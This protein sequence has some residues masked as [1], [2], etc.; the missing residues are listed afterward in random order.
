MGADGCGGG[1]IGITEEK[2]ELP[3]KSP[4]VK[5][6]DSAQLTTVVFSLWP[7]GL[8]GDGDISSYWLSVGFSR[9]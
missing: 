8:K 9:G 2:L 4:P 3:Y 5:E 1:G 6:R 7:G